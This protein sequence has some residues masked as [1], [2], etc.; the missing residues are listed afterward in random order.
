M[1]YKDTIPM[2]IDT[3]QLPSHTTINYYQY[4]FGVSKDDNSLDFF[5]WNANQL[6]YRD[7]PGLQSGYSVPKTFI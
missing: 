1:L 3:Y 7:M 2:S 6:K 5:L 4:L